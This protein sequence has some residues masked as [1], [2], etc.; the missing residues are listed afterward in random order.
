MEN[1]TAILDAAV[2][3]KDDKAVEEALQSADVPTST[4]EAIVEANLTLSIRRLMK[5]G[6][7]F[8]ELCVKSM[9]TGE[10]A[11]VISLHSAGVDVMA[12]DGAR[13][14]L[15]YGSSTPPMLVEGD[16][17]PTHDTRLSRALIKLLEARVVTADRRLLAAAVRCVQ[18]KM[19][20]VLLSHGANPRAD[21]VAEE[22][23]VEGDED[24]IE[25]FR[26][27]VLGTYYQ[28][29]DVLGALVRAAG[30]ARAGDAEW[31]AGLQQLS[32][33]CINRLPLS[34]LLTRGYLTLKG[35][36]FM[37]DELSMPMCKMIKN[38]HMDIKRAVEQQRYDVVWLVI[39]NDR[40]A[41]ERLMVYMDPRFHDL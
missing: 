20:T 32:K 36:Q 4:V 9:C 24:G 10:Y 13:T 12:V 17:A 28:A 33:R 35:P 15:V 2:E 27:A 23:D 29:R 18:S 38:G 30:P 5:L 3:A 25:I 31:V 21:K 22:D 39:T 34:D 26:A 1:N 37:V 7:D 11:S 14:M 8:T 6:Y 16:A 41:F 19:V 40:L